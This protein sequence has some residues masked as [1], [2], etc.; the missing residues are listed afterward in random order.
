[1]KNGCLLFCLLQ[2]FLFDVDFKRFLNCR[3]LRAEKE[4]VKYFKNSTMSNRFR[5]GDF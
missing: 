2:Y 5:T 3:S 1:M 4:A